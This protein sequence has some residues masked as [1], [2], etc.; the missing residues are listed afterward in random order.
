M[1]AVSLFPLYNH[2]R[3]QRPCSNRGRVQI[4]IQILVFFFVCDRHD[5]VLAKVCRV[6][7][8]QA[9]NREFLVFFQIRAQCQIWLVIFLNDDI[10]ASRTRWRNLCTDIRIFFLYICM[11]VSI[12]ICIFRLA[13]VCSCFRLARIRCCIRLG[14]TIRIRPGSVFTHSGLARWPGFVFTHS[15]LTRCCTSSACSFLACCHGSIL[16]CTGIR[17]WLACCT[18][19]VSAGAALACCQHQL[20]PACGFRNT[21]CS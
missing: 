8:H 21:R 4:V 9:Q 16:A 12:R 15:G 7:S 2:N 17:S 19:F 5:I 18:G 3:R 6:N 1:N 13:C 10:I 14:H 11:Y 20:L